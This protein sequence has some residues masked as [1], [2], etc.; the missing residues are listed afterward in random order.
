VRTQK[1]TIT[2]NKPAKDV[3]AFTLN[4][5]NTPKWV[6]PIVTEQTNEWPP[7]V[8]TVYRNQDAAGE[9]REITLIALEQDRTFTFGEADGF[10]IRYTFTAAG[11]D[12]TELECYLWMD[13]GEL[14]HLFSMKVLE[15][16]KQVIEVGQVHE[17]QSQLSARLARAAQQVTVGAR[18]VHYKQLT[19]EVIALA[20]RE[21]DGEPCV[22]YQAEYD[23]DITWIRPVSSWMEEVEI[24]GKKMKRFTKL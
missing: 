16:L 15:K 22:V 14:Q 5:E 2:I 7:R 17:D 21:E 13:R 8:G 23:D 1:L 19:Y 11:P 18:Y 24:D 10:H 6:E 4:P 3:F 20:L 12:A 9:W